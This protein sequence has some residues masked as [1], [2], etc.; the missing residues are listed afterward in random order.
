[1]PKSI[2]GYLVFGLLVVVAVAVI[3][4]VPAIRSLVTG[5]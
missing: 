2:K 5:A 4:R 3:W 1:M